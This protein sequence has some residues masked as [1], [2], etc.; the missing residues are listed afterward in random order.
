METLFTPW[1][2]A[3]LT[4]QRPDSGCFLCAAALRPDD[5]DGLVVATARHHLV[6]LNLHPYANGHLMVAPL[7]HVG[8]PQAS[9][10]EARAEL[11]PLVLRTQR[12]L[13]A[14]YAPH[15]FNLGMNLG[16]AAGAGVP[17]HFHFHV[18]PRWAGDTNFM[19]VLGAVRLIPEDLHQSRDRLR[20]LFAHD[21]Q[22]EDS[23]GGNR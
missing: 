12:L 1:R 15:G 7:A 10:P 23:I 9:P 5:P 16:Q 14:A 22:E 13:A 4:Q 20:A 21:Q 3:Y 17:D 2:Q 19:T 11:W 6:M 8:S 18:V